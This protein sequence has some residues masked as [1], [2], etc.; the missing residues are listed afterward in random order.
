MNADEITKLVAKRHGISI[1]KLLSKSRYSELIKAR[2]ELMA[3]MRLNGYSY[4][5]IGRFLGKNHTTIC[6]HLGSL[7]SSKK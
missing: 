7:A 6:F 2:R 4:S 1:E 5:A 3:A